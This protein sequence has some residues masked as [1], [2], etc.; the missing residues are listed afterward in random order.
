LLAQA[1]QPSEETG[2]SP[3][4][5]T[6]VYDS[7]DLLRSFRH[8]ERNVY[9]HSLREDSVLENFDIMK[10]AFPKFAA[11]AQAFIDGHEL[12]DVIEP[13]PPHP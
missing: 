2:R 4:I 1:A 11:E 12:K 8:I 13:A 5:S 9:R 3:I 7:L 6:D 10:I